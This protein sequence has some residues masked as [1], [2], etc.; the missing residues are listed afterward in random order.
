MNLTIPELSLVVLIGPS[1]CGK[2]TFAAKHFLPTE[3]ISSDYCRALVSDDENDLAA[4]AAAFR[5]LQAIAGERLRS[6]RLA[7]VDATSVQPE[8]R[9]PL[10]VIRGRPGRPRAGLSFRASP[11]HVDGE[12]RYRAVRGRQ[13][14]PEAVSCLARQGREGQPRARAFPRAAGEGSGPQDGGGRVPGRSD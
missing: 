3:V 14:R 9:K 1:G 5:V 8:S 2:S 4:T 10:V 13:S 6:G 11:R 12:G 7:V